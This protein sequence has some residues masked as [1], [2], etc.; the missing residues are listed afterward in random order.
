VAEFPPEVLEK[1][2]R[3]VVHIETATDSVDATER[4]D[5]WAETAERIRNGENF[6]EEMARKAS[7]DLL[8]GSR[9]IRSQGTATFLEHERAFFLVTAGHVLFDELKAKRRLRDREKF[10]EA[11]PPEQRKFM[12][13]DEKEAVKETIYDII[14][15]V[16][17]IDEVTAGKAQELH[18]FLM[19][20][21]AGVP[22]MW[23]YTFSKSPLDLAIV[24]LSGIHRPFAEQLL[25]RGYRPITLSDIA[26]GPSREGAQVFSVGFPGHMSILGERPLHLAEQQ[27][28]SESYSLPSFIFGRVG[29]L[30]RRLPHFWCDFGPYPGHSGAPIVEDGKMV[31][32]ISTQGLSYD[33]VFRKNPKPEAMKEFPY[34]RTDLVAETRISFGRG[35][36]TR[37]VKELLDVQLKRDR[38]VEESRRPSTSPVK[39]PGSGPPEPV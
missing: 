7:E 1:W 21:G 22:W 36:Q 18:R 4:A 17:S 31:G 11:W 16:P 26:D 37:F 28:A 14:F 3:A 32:V 24:S 15:V 25:T 30:H 5:R 13:A 6:S 2:K 19:N 23:P 20:L 12:I 38:S 35:F 8:K 33:E 10:A 27:W 9:D 39:D 34:L 29:M